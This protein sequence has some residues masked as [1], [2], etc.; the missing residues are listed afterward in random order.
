M[1]KRGYF[2]T[3]D[4]IIGLTMLAI[5]IFLFYSVSTPFPTLYSQPLSLSQDILDALAQ[6]KLYEFNNAFIDEL[7]AT[8]NI[9]RMDNTVLEQIAIF[10]LE[11]KINPNK[12]TLASRLVEELVKG[13][14]P[15]QYGFNLK[16]EDELIYETSAIS[17]RTDIIT[18]SK[19]M[20]M[21]VI[22]K[23]STFGPLTAEVNVWQK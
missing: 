5:G 3:L 4:A 7:R 6:I 14:V 13:S 21:G 17:A 9:K 12:L 23:A 16:I 10:Y 19:T 20:V 2:F 11:S 8:E 22:S 1:E 18:S 15:Q